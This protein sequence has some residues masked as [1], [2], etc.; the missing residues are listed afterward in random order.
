ME[1]KEGKGR[2]EERKKLKKGFFVN[3]NTH[4]HPIIFPLPIRHG[5]VFFFL[6]MLTFRPFSKKGMS[7][8]VCWLKTMSWTPSHT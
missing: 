6:S 1:G 2:M 8:I 5:N 4:A 7:C 3:K